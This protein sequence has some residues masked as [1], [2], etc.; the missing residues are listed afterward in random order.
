MILPSEI[1]RIRDLRTKEAEAHINLCGSRVVVVSK[2]PY[3]SY[4]NNGAAEQILGNLFSDSL[5]GSGLV[6]GD[7]IRGEVF[8]TYASDTSGADTDTILSVVVNGVTAGSIMITRT[9]LSGDLIA[10]RC[11]F[12]LRFQGGENVTINSPAKSSSTIAHC[13]ISAQFG[14]LSTSTW[15]RSQGVQD[16]WI[17][18]TDA[19][20]AAVNLAIPVNVQLKYEGTT[21]GNLTIYGGALEG[22]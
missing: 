18:S 13:V 16:S 11:S 10:F 21:G 19:I 7:I 12:L 8:G 5:G 2:A 20:G 9:D 3:A 15:S 1:E 6:R 4:T 22:L 14:D 17:T